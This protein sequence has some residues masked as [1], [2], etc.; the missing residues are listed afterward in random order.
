MKR[1]VSQPVIIPL[2]AA[3]RMS[4]VTEKSELPA[5]RTQ[6]NRLHSIADDPQRDPRENALKQVR[7]R[8]LRM[9]VDNEWDRSHGNRA[10]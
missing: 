4:P 6:V 9:I 1:T 2:R 8:L 5:R 7:A 10:S 3:I